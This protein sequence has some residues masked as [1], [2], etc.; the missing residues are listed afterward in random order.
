MHWLS[1]LASGLITGTLGAVFAWFVGEAVAEYRNVS[2]FE[3]ERMYLV[4]LVFVPLGFLTGLGLGLWLASKGAGGFGSWAKQLAV[5]V[6]ATAGLIGLIGGLVFAGSEHAPTIDGKRLMLE[7]EVRLPASPEPPE[8]REV[9]ASLIMGTHESRG[10]SFALDRVKMTPNGGQTV[11]PGDVSLY[12]TSAN[13]VLG[14]A[15]R[16]DNGETIPTQNFAVPLPARP[17]PEHTAWSPWTLP[18]SRMSG[19]SASPPAEHCEV[20]FR[21]PPVPDK[22]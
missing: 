16:G 10:V 17:G 7:I 14:L 11:V 5:A 21:V 4:A 8:K 19:G 15:Y 1:L 22:Y 9:V 13:R 3:G 18:Y 2:N 20:R 12:H 6:A